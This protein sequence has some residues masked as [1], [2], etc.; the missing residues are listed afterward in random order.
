MPVLKENYKAELPTLEL[1]TGTP[2]LALFDETLQPILN[3][4]TGINL[5]AYMEDFQYVYQEGERRSRGQ[6]SP[7]N[8]ATMVFKT[9]DPDTLDIAPLQK[10][11]LIFIQFG[12]IFSNGK[13]LSSPII[14]VAIRQ[15]DAV[16]DEEGTT[17]TIRTKDTT[18]YLRYFPAFVPKSDTDNILNW[19]VDGCGSQVGVLIK[20]FKRT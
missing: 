12:Y 6:E 17:I 10:N 20:R 5:G 13:A 11:A 9:G 1:G 19:L 16:L 2:Y 8:E 3:P 7:G 4:I 14:S 15:V 18:A